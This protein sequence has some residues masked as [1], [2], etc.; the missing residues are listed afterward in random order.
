MPSDSGSIGASGDLSA[1]RGVIRRAGRV[2]LGARVGGEV[3]SHF[4]RDF[5]HLLGQAEQLSVL[6]V[7]TLNGVGVGPQFLRQL[8]NL[9]R[10]VEQLLVLAILEFDRRPGDRGADNARRG[11]RSRRAGC[12][13]SD[14]R[15]RV[16]CIP[17]SRAV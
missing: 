9:F 11:L 8:E 12:G 2:G 5:E 1:S 7:L 15:S 17:W 16:W 4:R 14:L 3:G 13:R 6:L 10:E